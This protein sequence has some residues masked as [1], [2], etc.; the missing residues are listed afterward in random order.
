MGRIDLPGATFVITDDHHIFVNGKK[1]TR[2]QLHA[3]VTTTVR[4]YHSSAPHACETVLGQVLESCKHDRSAEVKRNK[5]D[6]FWRDACFE[7]FRGVG[8]EHADAHPGGV[9]G[10]AGGIDS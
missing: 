2:L 6:G 3:L 10:T 4:T 8:A 5:D 7:G 9:E 1:L